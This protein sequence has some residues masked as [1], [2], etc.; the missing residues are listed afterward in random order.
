MFL[1]DTLEILKLK[2]TNFKLGY[3]ADKRR[4]SHLV[5]TGGPKFENGDLNP[6]ITPKF[7]RN[8]KQHVIAIQEKRLPL[9]HL[10]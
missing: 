6:I 5:L 9:H 1:S 10:N 4:A 7:V 3:L 8:V 2:I